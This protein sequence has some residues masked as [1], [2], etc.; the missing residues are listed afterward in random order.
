MFF[1]ALLTCTA[2]KTSNKLTAR[3]GHV[4]L[5]LPVEDDQEGEEEIVVF[6]G[7]DNEGGFFSDLVIFT[8]SVC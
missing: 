2:V 3:A 1:L 4:A 8:P 6:G 7:G 5:Y